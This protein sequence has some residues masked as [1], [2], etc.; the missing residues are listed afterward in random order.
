[1]V[2]GM[3]GAMDLVAGARNVVVAMQHMAKDGSPKILEHCSL[4]LTGRSCVHL[5][6][7]ELAVIEVVRRGAL[8]EGDRSGH[9]G[10]SRE[11]GDRHEA[12]RRRNVKT[13]EA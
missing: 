1:M 3:G 12:S 4:P 8:A 2:K 10:R 6:I 9:D 11:Q 7:T 5:I 13:M